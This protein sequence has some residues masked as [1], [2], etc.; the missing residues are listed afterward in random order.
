MTDTPRIAG[1]FVHPVKGCAGIPLKAARLTPRGLEHDRRW[2]IVDMEGK[3]LSQRQLPRMATVRPG[4]LDGR[5]R[6]E[7]GGHALTL[8]L[9]DAGTVTKVRV[10]GDE[11]AALR[12]DPRIDAAL[13]DHL[14]LPV[15]LVRFP[16]DAV[17]PCDPD[18]APPGSHTGFADGFP[19]LV[20]SE[21]S[22]AELNAALAARDAAAVP[23]ARFRPNIV[24]AGLPARAED[25][26]D[27][28]TIADGTELAL[29]KRCDRC[30]V[31]TVDQASGEKTGREPLATLARIRRNVATGGA[32]FGQNAVPLL[33][34]DADRAIR[35][36]DAVRLWR[37]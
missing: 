7:V 32:W 20:T 11:V 25:G 34:A 35:L 36:G 19:L 12:V 29:V 17:R 9:A 6:L 24:L 18:H 13:S 1:L 8:P 31:I 5:L 30:V 14:G 33:A 21:A 22:L 16:D 26:H 28:L 27:R 4:F 15:R 2:M 37:R 23:M 10:W 3:F